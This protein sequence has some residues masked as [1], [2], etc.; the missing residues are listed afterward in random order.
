MSLA[1]QYDF[2]LHCRFNSFKW[3]ALE[4]AEALKWAKKCKVLEKTLDFCILLKAQLTLFRWDQ[5][6]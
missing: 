4:R 5:N 1:N 2:V 6:F 3:T